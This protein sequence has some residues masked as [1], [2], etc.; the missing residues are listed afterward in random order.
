[1]SGGA[2][3]VGRCQVCGR[4]N[5]PLQR[6]YYNYDIPCECCGPAHFVMVRHCSNCTPQEPMYSKVEFKT[7]DLKNPYKLAQKIID[8]AEQQENKRRSTQVVTLKE[9]PESLSSIES[10]NKNEIFNY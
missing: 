8:F 9:K 1:M 2:C 7:E 5:V 6:T 3:E 10:E 4:E